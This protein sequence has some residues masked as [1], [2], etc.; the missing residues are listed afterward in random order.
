MKG[1][2]ARGFVRQYTTK[3]VAAK[4][5]KEQLLNIIAEQTDSP[6]GS[7][8]WL[9]HYPAALTALYQGLTEEE[10]LTCQQSMELW[11]KEDPS[12]LELQR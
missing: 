6:L 10:L 4:L 3:E 9:R 8:D 12:P 7:K 5:H 11:N 1:R 2:A